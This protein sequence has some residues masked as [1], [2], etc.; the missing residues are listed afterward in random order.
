MQPT[1]PF[2]ARK[3]SLAVG[4]TPPPVL[5]GTRG[6]LSLPALTLGVWPLLHLSVLPMLSPTL[7]KALPAWRRGPASSASA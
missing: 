1:Q 2:S 4:A 7:S 6:A 5:G 3:A